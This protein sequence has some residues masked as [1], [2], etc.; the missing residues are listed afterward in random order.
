MRLRLARSTART[1]APRHGQRGARWLLAG[2]AIA[3]MT[4]GTSALANHTVLVEGE[5]DFD[6]D[7]MIGADEDGDGDQ[8]FGSI[9]AAVAGVSDNGKVM[10][11][12]SGRFLEQVRLEGVGVTV[13]EAA[14]GVDA[15]IGAFQGGGDRGAND[16]RQQQ[17]GI[18]VHTDGSFPIVIRNITSRNWTD[19]IAIRGSSRVTL[20]DV[21]LDSN[22][23]YGIHVEGTSRVVVTNS[24]VTSSGYR[25]S[26]TL[27]L[28][29]GG[30]IAP[31]PGTGIAFEDDSSGIVS[32][33]HVTQSFATGIDSNGRVR[34][35]AN[36]VFDNGRNYD[37]FW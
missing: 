1:L 4:L 13:L 23:N 29:P 17:E 11:V 14:P 30:D 37:G 12:T 21:R 16:T 36:T 33:T 19:G 8:V 34:L 5:S 15:T 10:I 24:S 22:V 32:F 25:R 35:L 3:G 7:G 9:G 18:V 2:V 20:D 6:G 28:T 26:G 31:G 27:G